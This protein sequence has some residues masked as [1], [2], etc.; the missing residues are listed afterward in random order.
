MYI[1]AAV[2]VLVL[3]THGVCGV[4]CLLQLS[5]R[6]RNYRLLPLH[7]FPGTYMYMYIHTTVCTYV[8]TCTVMIV[9]ICTCMYVCIIVYIH[10][11]TYVLLCIYVHIVKCFCR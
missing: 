3:H 7:H 11:C 2:D 6:L 1:Y 9:F 8:Y 5:G 10:V 4:F